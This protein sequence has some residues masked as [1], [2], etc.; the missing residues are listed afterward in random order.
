MASNDVNSRHNSSE[1][2]RTVQ[3]LE[4]ENLKVIK[5]VCDANGIAY[6]LTGGTLLGALRHQGFIPWDD[7]V[8]IAVP[9]EDYERLV[10]VLPTCLP[11]HMQSVTKSSDPN[12]KCYFTR[13][14]NNKRH[15]I[16]DQGQ[17]QICIGIWTD[18][19]P[20]DGLPTNVFARYWHLS[21]VMLDKLLY[22]FTQIDHVQTNKIRPW[23]ENALIRFG[24][25]THIGHLLD[26]NKMLD[27]LDSRVKKYRYRSSEYVWNFSGD[28]GLREIVPKR[29]LGGRR[30]GI[31]EG[32]EVNIP[33]AAEEYVTRIYGKD[34]MELPPV[35]KRVSHAVNLVET[36]E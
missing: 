7:D 32:L 1:D 2:L 11:A 27:K 21:M 16:W 10:E 19:F 18:I 14:I 34:W 4:F 25:F 35:E 22:K 15:L 33:E 28:Y 6:F 12:Y 17:Y 29:C 26:G 36:D 9:R 30:T 31:F 13:L 23:Y 20:I 8:D 3:E 5:Q 24:Q